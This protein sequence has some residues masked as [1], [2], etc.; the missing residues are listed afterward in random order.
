[1]TLYEKVISFYSELAPTTNAFGKETVNSAF[2]DGTIILQ[3]DSDGK[4][5]YIAKWLHPDF[6]QP[7]QAELD[8]I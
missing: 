5:D 4:G 1:M 8:A 2:A 6:A 3:N 7:T